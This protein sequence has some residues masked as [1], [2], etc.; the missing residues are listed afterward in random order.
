MLA[1][2]TGVRRYDN[3]HFVIPP[4]CVVIPARACPGGK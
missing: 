2:D 3:Y 4:H 1:L